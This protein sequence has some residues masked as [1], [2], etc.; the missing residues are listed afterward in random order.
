METNELILKLD[1]DSTLPLIEGLGK[2]AYAIAVAHGFKGTEQE[3]LNSLQ[4]VQ[5]PQ[6]EPGPKGEPFRYEDFTPEQLEA[7]KGPKGDKGEDGRD[8][9][10]ATADN[11]YRTLLEGNVWCESASVDHVLIAVLGNSGKPFPRTGF[12][13][14]KVLNTFRGQRVIGVEGEPHYKVKVGETEFKLGPAGTG[15][16]TL[17]DGL[18]DDDVKITYHNFLGENVGDFIIAGVPD[19]TAAQPDEIYTALGSKYSKYGRKLVINI[20]NQETDND[21]SKNN[22]NFLGKWTE[23]DFDSIEL[24]TNGKK[25]LRLY[26]RSERPGLPSIPIFVNK[27]ELVTFY[28]LLIP[29]GN[30]LINIGTK[31]DGLRQINFRLETL[32][33]DSASHQY[34]N[35]GSEPL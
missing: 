6:G 28:H 26:L 5:G 13:E 33:W 8:G 19:D 3:W 1:K 7:L 11:T 25:L 4:G 17:E 30:T 20:T 18:G 12:K 15:N 2:S 24:V 31:G 16:I 35:T 21:W 27:P 14:L 9:T 34:I 23:R 32:E 22:F 29:N 10:S